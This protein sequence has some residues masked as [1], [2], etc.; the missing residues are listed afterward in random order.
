MNH[1]DAPSGLAPPPDP[2]KDRCKP[3]PTHIANLLTLVHILLIYGRH[4]AITIERRAAHRS[5]SNLALFFGTARLPVIQARLNRGLLRIQALQR[6][7]LDR[8]RRGRDLVF[9]K[10]RVRAPRKPRPAL[11][12]AA[13]PQAEPPAPR[14]APVRRPARDAAPDPDALPTLEQ[15]MADI[16]RRPIG[17]TIADICRDLGVSPRLCHNQFWI[18]LFQAIT[19]YRG[20]LPALMQ[21]LLRR[22]VAFAP[23]WDRDPNL[24]IP[25]YTRDSVRRVLGFC[26]GEQWP[27]APTWLPRL[28]TGLRAA[29][30]TRPP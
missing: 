10:Q 19:W 3:V 24:A 23:E 7:L 9:P 14:P 17:C 30:A 1:A 4:L 16:R 8:A 21:D 15:L 13:D 20:N 27:V 6:V 26:L 28:P 29:A 22:E 18:V 5:F 11:P 12:P 2:P 25:E